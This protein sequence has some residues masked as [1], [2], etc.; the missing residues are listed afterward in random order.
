MNDGH[1]INDTVALRSTWKTT[2]TTDHPI[3]IYNYSLSARSCTFPHSFFLLSVFLCSI[4]LSFLRSSRPLS[5][6]LS[7]AH[8]FVRIILVFPILSNTPLTNT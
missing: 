8:R 5:L 1:D 3:R 7:L 2:L 6:S 4:L